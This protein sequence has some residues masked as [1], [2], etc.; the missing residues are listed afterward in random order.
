VIGASRAI[1][2]TAVAA[3]LLASSADAQVVGAGGQYQN[4][5]MQ[6]LLTVRDSV[7]SVRREVARFRRDLQLAGAQTVTSRARRLSSACEGLQTAL[8][9]GA[10][11]LQSGSGA[12]VTERRAS[13]AMQAQIR[14]TIQVLDGEC[15]IGLRPEGP[16]AWPDSLKAWGPNR[17][18]NVEGALSA[19]EGAAVRFAKAADLDF[20]PKGQ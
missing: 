10:P 6:A 5:Q 1:K 9:D 11:D 15:R 20:P 7:L 16:G 14:E 8:R 18:S 12:S 2:A 19:Y 17:T 13:G 3:V 4:P